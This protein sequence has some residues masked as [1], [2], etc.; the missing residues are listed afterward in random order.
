MHVFKD[1][2]YYHINVVCW[3]NGCLIFHHITIDKQRD[4]SQP[5]FFSCICTVVCSNKW[6]KLFPTVSA[7]CVLFVL[8]FFFLTFFESINKLLMIHIWYQI[9][10]EVVF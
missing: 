8:V 1:A 9:K 5:F 10:Q 4:L 7:G 6:K 3:N 2:T